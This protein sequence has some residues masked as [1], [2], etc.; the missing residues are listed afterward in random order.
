[1][2]HRVCNEERSNGA[3]G[4]VL[5]WFLAAI[6]LHGCGQGAAA[7][8]WF[9]KAECKRVG[10]VDQDTGAE[11][12]GIEDIVF[13]PESGSLYLSAYDRLA[14]E[15][16]VS[17]K[18][19]SVPEGGL[20]SVKLDDLRSA[21]SPLRLPRLTAGLPVPGGWRPHGLGLT[22]PDNGERRLAVINRR[23]LMS[24]HG[25]WERR[26]TIEIL[27]MDEMGPTRIGSLD[28]PELC[29]ANNLTFFG[30]NRLLV[31]IDRETC[32][33]F[34]WREFVLGQPRGRVLE[35]ELDEHGGVAQSIRTVR[36][37]LPVANGIAASRARSHVFV[38]LTRGTAILVGHLSA[39][40]PESWSTIPLDGGPD[41]LS[42]VGDGPLVAA[43]L[44]SLFRFALY[45]YDLFGIATAPSVID[46]IDPDNGAVVPLYRDEEGTQFSGATS[47]IFYDGTLIAGSVRDRGVLVCTKAAKP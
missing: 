3:L 12:S 41:N 6:W 45:R 8:P 34:P 25:G 29:N 30:P 42:L 44:P 17:N 31:T 23:Y 9:G 40:G 32:G 11:I 4:R 43:V 7:E 1:M 18:A 13:E 33:R 5:K 28:Q 37:E 16:A 22:Q 15:R 10:L 21:A 19:A 2:R 47:A 35:I 38:A 36:S 39:T 27:Q 26:D 20:Y 46:R 24:Q 14:V